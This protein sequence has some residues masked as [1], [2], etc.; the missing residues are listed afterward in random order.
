MNGVS[1]YRLKQMDRDGSYEYS[2]AVPVYVEAITKELAIDFV[3][4][5]DQQV[6]AYFTDAEVHVQQVE[7]YDMVGK[8]VY[9][10]AM[11]GNGGVGYVTMP[12]H[13]FNRGVYLMRVSD[14]VHTAVKKFAY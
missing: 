4:A 10:K 7:V 13:Y 14:G 11:T 9:R 2:P 1:Y 5:T 8:L 3:A 12:A 6:R